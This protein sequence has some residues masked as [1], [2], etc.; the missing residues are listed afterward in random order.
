MFE[1]KPPSAVSQTVEENTEMQ[2]RK[3]EAEK[4]S[5][6]DSDEE[7]EDDNSSQLARGTM[8][9]VQERGPVQNGSASSAEEQSG[10]EPTCQQ[11]IVSRRIGVMDRI[12]KTFGC[13]PSFFS[14]LN[15]STASPN[16]QQGSL[17]GMPIAPTVKSEQVSHLKSSMRLSSS[18]VGEEMKEPSKMVTFDLVD[19]KEKAV[20][21]SEEPAVQEL[22]EQIFPGQEEI[23]RQSAVFVQLQQQLSKKIKAISENNPERTAMRTELQTELNNLRAENNPETLPRRTEIK[24]ELKKLK[25]M[26][27]TDAV[28]LAQIAQLYAEAYP[29]AREVAQQM[30]DWVQEDPNRQHEFAALMLTDIASKVLEI[31]SKMVAPHEIELIKRANSTD[32]SKKS[33]DIPYERTNFEVYEKYKLPSEDL[34]HGIMISAANHSLQNLQ[35]FKKILKKILRQNSPEEIENDLRQAQIDKAIKCYELSEEKYGCVDAR[36]SLLTRKPVYIPPEKRDNVLI[37]AL[38]KEKNT[39]NAASKF[40]FSQPGE[41]RK[42]ELIADPPRVKSTAV[43]EALSLIPSGLQSADQFIEMLQQRRKKE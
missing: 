6:S 32:K 2:R 22:G 42:S 1:E 37:Q 5:S 12:R 24:N 40:F 11:S 8:G 4:K 9:A 26:P 18:R 3:E 16:A 14:R 21:A 31:A 39:I 33:F 41:I 35:N 34:E 7:G 38:N 43:T 28:K 36:L 13:L 29:Q 19:A 23:E 15:R 27:E 25:T 30:F 10:T 20:D 17:M